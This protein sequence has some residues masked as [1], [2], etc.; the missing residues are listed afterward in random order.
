[1]KNNTLLIIAI[2]G[3]ALLGACRGGDHTTISTNQDGHKTTLEY[4]GK[5][6]FTDDST[7]IKSMSP[8]SYVSFKTDGEEL[9]AERNYQGI[10]YSLPDGTKSNILNNEGKQLIAKVIKNVRRMDKR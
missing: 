10:T 5:I 3:M 2:T 8:K 6:V 7:A 9:I 4:Y 1:M